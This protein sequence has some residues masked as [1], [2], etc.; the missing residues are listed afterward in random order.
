MREFVFFFPI[1]T[2]ISLIYVEKKGNS[3]TLR[4]YRYGYDDEVNEALV[5]A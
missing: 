4:I 5:F 3:G 2:N 1:F